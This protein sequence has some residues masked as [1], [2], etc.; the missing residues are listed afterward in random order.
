MLEQFH[1]TKTNY[2]CSST[3][4][5]EFMTCYEATIQAL[6]LIFLSRYMLLIP[7]QIL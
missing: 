3:I 5:R 6:R 2:N 1:G 4:Q 7:L